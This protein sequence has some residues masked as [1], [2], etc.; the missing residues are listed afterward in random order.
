MNYWVD[1]VSEWV[2]GR[3]WI[4]GGKRFLHQNEIDEKM[5]RVSSVFCVYK[6]RA[7]ESDQE[8]ISLITE[9]VGGRP[10]VLN[11]SSSILLPWCTSA[12]LSDQ[13]DRVISW[14]SNS[15]T[16][17]TCAAIKS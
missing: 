12:Q 9:R 10:R 15:L 6:N 8:E 2:G 5:G 11:E 17:N 16:M 13:S 7:L 1:P 4:E 14:W 3:H